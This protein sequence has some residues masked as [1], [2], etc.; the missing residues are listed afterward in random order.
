MGENFPYLI[1]HPMIKHDRECT[2]V[3]KYTRMY[4][5]SLAQ[6]ANRAELLRL[7][8]NTESY[9]Y[10]YVLKSNRNKFYKRYFPPD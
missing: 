4:V 3:H 7:K 5:N 9:I 6:P 8:F 1:Y 10:T 2:H